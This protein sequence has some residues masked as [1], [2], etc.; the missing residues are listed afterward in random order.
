ML[1]QVA[2]M[3]DVSFFV[4][5]IQIVWHHRRTQ[6]DCSTTLDHRPVCREKYDYFA[7]LNALIFFANTDYRILTVAI[8]TLL[9]SGK[10]SLREIV[11]SLAKI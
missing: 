10:V 2:A 1:I 7:S 6:L 4:I 9:T 11:K 5:V 3:R 8:Q